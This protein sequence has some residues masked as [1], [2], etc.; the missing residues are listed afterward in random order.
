MIFATPFL[1]EM[2]GSR[3]PM[4]CGAEQGEASPPVFSRQE[5]GKV[6]G[7]VIRC[8]NGVFF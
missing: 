2:A 8:G 5:T 6:T 3:H 7:K 4:K 1:T